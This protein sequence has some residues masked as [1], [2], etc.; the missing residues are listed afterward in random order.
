[1]YLPDSDRGRHGLQAVPTPRPRGVGSIRLMVSLLECKNRRSPTFFSVRTNYV[2]NPVTDV[3]KP[4]G[5]CGIPYFK[6][7]FTY[8]TFGSTDPLLEKSQEKRRG[9]LETK[10]YTDQPRMEDFTPRDLS[11]LFLTRT[12]VSKVLPMSRT[13]KG[14]KRTQNPEGA[15]LSYLHPWDHD[16]IFYTSLFGLRLRQR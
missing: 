8:S 10:G 9:V 14:N 4:L 13:K 15:F 12:P 6:I 16:T 2:S 1:M 7:K 5:V 11:T 3:R